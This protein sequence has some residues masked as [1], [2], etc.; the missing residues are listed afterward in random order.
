MK[1]L[2]LIFLIP[3]TAGAKIFNCEFNIAS[4]GQTVKASEV[5]K[6]IKKISFD[7]SSKQGKI[8]NLGGVSIS[9][10]NKSYHINLKYE[11]KARNL[12]FTSS[13]FPA[14]DSFS[15]EVKPHYQFKCSSRG[16]A[17]KTA[18]D[19][20]IDPNASLDKYTQNLWV[21]T[22][23]ELKFRYNQRNV[24]GKM[25]PIIFQ[26]GKLYTA[27]S[28]RDIEGNWCIF[29]IQVK[30]DENTFINKWTKLK[31]ESFN[32]LSNNPTHNVYAYTFVDISGGKKRSETSRYA[33]FSLECKIKKSVPFN[34]NLFH[35]IT[36]KRL[37]LYLNK[38]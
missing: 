23:V 18:S 27:D 2:I 7:T 1:A 4:P 22:N 38:E 29:N 25:R 9:I 24:V 14:R 26:D 15:I 10:W 12:S 30:L 11:E 28:E 3:F 6:Y 19:D 31:V 17:K 34:L 5:D 37:S 35:K 20:K 32:I 13:Y 21:K 33:P 16:A 8:I 36:G